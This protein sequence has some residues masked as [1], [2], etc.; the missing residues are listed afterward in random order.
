MRRQ[1]ERPRH[2]DRLGVDLLQ[3]ELD[4]ELGHRIIA[5]LGS[6]R[7]KGCAA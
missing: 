3:D 1:L 2:G 4:I 5:A 6:K 7:T